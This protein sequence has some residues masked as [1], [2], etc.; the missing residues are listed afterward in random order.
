VTVHSASQPPQLIF[1]EHYTQSA[2]QHRSASLASWSGRRIRVK[3]IS[4]CGPKDN[5]N[6]DH[7][8]WGDVRVISASS[9]EAFTE[10]VRFMTWA[11][12][13]WFR[14]GFYFPRVRSRSA[15]LEFEVEGTEDVWLSDFSVHA[16]PDVIYRGFE[17]G[18]VLANPSL[19]EY[20]FDL[21]SLFPEQR[22]RRLEGSSRQD[23]ATNNGSILGRRVKLGPKDGLF[24]VEC[25]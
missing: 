17:N 5:T 22:F 21:V 23:T 2:W 12:A 4:D 25:R 6:T 11:D 7:S 19:H 13:D 3:F 14:A 10:P 24:L 8:L 15:D 18:L 9:S 1:E 16:S 20:E